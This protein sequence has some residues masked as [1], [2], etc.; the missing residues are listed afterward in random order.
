[1]LPM[2]PQQNPMDAKKAALQK[3]LQGMADSRGLQGM[4]SRGANVYNGGSSAA[5]VGGGPQFGPPQGNQ[6]AAAPSPPG[7][8]GQLPPGLGGPMPQQSQQAQTPDYSGQLQAQMQQAKAALQ[9]SQLKQAKSSSQAG[10]GGMSGVQN[11]LKRRM[12]NSQKQ[13]LTDAASKVRNASLGG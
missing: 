13:R 11:A 10:G 5:T 2:Q 4:F 6:N 7:L 3:R 9:A 12:E 8:G 1:M